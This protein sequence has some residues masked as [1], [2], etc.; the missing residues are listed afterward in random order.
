MNMGQLINL[1]TQAS[2]IVYR[3]N[4]KNIQTRL[5]RLPLCHLLS[6]APEFSPSAVSTK[7][8]IRSSSVF[9]S[10]YSISQSVRPAQGAAWDRTE[11]SRLLVCGK[12]KH[13]L[14]L[15]KKQTTLG[16]PRVG[17]K[18]APGRWPG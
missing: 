2:E 1:G 11:N 14:L 7:L 15:Y 16:C 10:Q 5:P 6:R 12:P 9:H 3:M 8:I 13:N 17:G 18:S 4:A